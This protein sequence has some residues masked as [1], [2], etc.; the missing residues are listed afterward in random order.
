MQLTAKEGCGTEKFKFRIN[1][2]N[3]ADYQYCGFVRNGK[4]DKLFFSL[5]QYL[6]LSKM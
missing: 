4:S 3:L 6:I 2:R 1:S 5:P